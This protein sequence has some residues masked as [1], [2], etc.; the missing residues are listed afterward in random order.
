MAKA[1]GSVQASLLEKVEYLANE[2]WIARRRRPAQ[3]RVNKALALLSS[4]GT[5]P[6]APGDEVPEAYKVWEREQQSKARR[7]AG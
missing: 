3:N 2:A 4:E 5:Q 6:P 1:V 7:K